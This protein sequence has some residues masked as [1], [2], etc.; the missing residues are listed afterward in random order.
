MALTIEPSIIYGG[1]FLMV[2]EEN[3]VVTDNGFE[4]LSHRADR[5]LPIITYDQLIKETDNG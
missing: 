4:L 2:A 5:D 3:L 1:G